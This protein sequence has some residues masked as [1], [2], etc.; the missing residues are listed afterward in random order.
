VTALAH[1]RANHA[2]PESLTPPL[3]P[4]PWTRTYLAATRHARRAISEAVP[5]AYIA[6]EREKKKRHVLPGVADGKD[7]SEIFRANKETGDLRESESERV[8]IHFYLALEDFST[9]ASFFLAEYAIQ[10]AYGQINERGYYGLMYE[11]LLLRDFNYDAEYRVKIQNVV[12]PTRRA[13]HA[14]TCSLIVWQ[15]CFN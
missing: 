2:A 8:Q 4:R 14:R 7:P 13:T 11:K 10:D 6:K 1:S 3:H 15:A 12:A 5:S 9:L